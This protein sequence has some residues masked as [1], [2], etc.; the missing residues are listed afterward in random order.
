MWPFA[1]TCW[2]SPGKI[3]GDILQDQYKCGFQPVNRQHY[4]D[5]VGLRCGFYEDD[6]FPLVQCF[7]PD[8]EQHLP[9]DDGCN[10]YVK[11]PAVA[12]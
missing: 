5:Y 6:P 3:C 9:W 7:W 12:L 4:R 10:E 8:K 2:N 11:L 1:T